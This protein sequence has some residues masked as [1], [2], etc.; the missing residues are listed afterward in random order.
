MKGLFDRNDR[1]AEVDKFKQELTSACL[2]KKNHLFGNFSYEGYEAIFELM[3]SFAEEEILINCKSYDV[4][5]NDEIFSLFE[6]ICDRFNKKNKE[7]LVITYDGNKSEKFLELEKKYKFFTY[8]PCKC[9]NFKECNNFIV[10]DHVKY[11]LEDNIFNR[12]SLKDQIKACVNFNDP[13]KA[14]QL[15]MLVNSLK[16][17]L[18]VS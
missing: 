6:L 11:W 8:L 5:F 10:V 3:L 17:K 4:L 9:E 1:Q 18:N 7:I 16:V 12:E 14:A 15:I 2:N 13:I